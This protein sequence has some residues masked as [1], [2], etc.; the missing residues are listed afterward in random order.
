MAID[1]IENYDKVLHEQI[2]YIGV[3]FEIHNILGDRVLADSIDNSYW[4]VDSHYQWEDDE[5][6]Y[7]F[8]MEDIHFIPLRSI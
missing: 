8:C 6:C 5:L 4:L 3:Y 1:S 7:S 2:N